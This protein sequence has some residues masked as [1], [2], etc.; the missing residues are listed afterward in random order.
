MVANALAFQLG[1]FA[2]VLGGANQLPWAGTLVAVLIAAW[3][4]S[5][6][7]RPGRELT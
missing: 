3:H 1:W 6:A 7:Q 4:L 2:C 5:R